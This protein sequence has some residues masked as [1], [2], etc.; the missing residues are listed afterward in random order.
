MAEKTLLYK[1][2]F[3]GT[4]KAHKNLKQLEGDLH[5]LTKEQ[6]AHTKAIKNKDKLTDKEIAKTN[7]LKIALK[8]TRTAIR[9]NRNEVIANV[10]AS[11]KLDNSYNSLVKRNKSLAIAVKKLA[12]PLTK[13]K[14]KFD[15]LTA[16]INKNNNSLKAMDKTMGNNQRNV[17][18]YRSAVGGLTGAFGVSLNAASLFLA[19]KNVI[20][21]IKEFD[22]KMATVKAISGATASEFDRLKKSAKELGASTMFTATQVGQLQLEFSKLGFSTEEILSATEA[23]LNLATATESDLGESAV[24]AASTIRGFGLSA[25]DT[26]KVTDIMAKS[27]TSSA[28]DLQKFGTSM[29]IIA[30]VAKNSN[31]TLAETTAILGKVM[32]AGVDASSAGTALRNIFLELSKQGLT[33]NQAMEKIQKS[34]NKNKVAMDLFGKRGAS[35]ANI[36][37]NNTHE[38]GEFK[39][40]L[41]NSAGSAKTMADIVGDT[42]HG[43]VKRLSSAWEG[44]ILGLDS[45]DGVLSRTISGFLEMSTA[46][47]SAITPMHRQ[48]EAIVQEKIDTELLVTQIQL[49]NEG[50]EE[51]IKLINELRVK[52]PEF[53]GKIKDEAVTN[54]LLAKRIKEVNEQMIAKIVLAH[55]QEEIEEQQEDAASKLRA[56]EGAK[57]RLIHSLI[58]ARDDYNIKLLETGTLEER[59][60]HARKELDKKGILDQRKKTDGVDLYMATMETAGNLQRDMGSD[61]QLMTMFNKDYNSELEK[62]NNLTTEK[63]KLARELGIL[64]GDTDEKKEMKILKAGIERAHTIQGMFKNI[65]DEYATL[66][67]NAE[68][69]V[70]NPFFGKEA[71]KRGEQAKE[72][73]IQLQK[74]LALV[75]IMNEQKIA[76]NIESQKD[77]DK[78]EK[79]GIKNKKDAEAE[80]TRLKSEKNKKIKEE[81]KKAEDLRKA[82]L[83]KETQDIQKGYDGTVES[84]KTMQRKI[85]EAQLLSLK[86]QKANYEKYGQSTIELDRQISGMQFSMDSADLKEKNK[87]KLDKKAQD[88]KDAKV[89]DKLKEQANS[90]YLKAT[91]DLLSGVMNLQQEARE[92]EVEREI[93]ML[94]IKVHNGLISE[95]EFEK[96]SLELRKEAFAKQKKTEMAMAVIHGAV[97]V[98]KTIAQL[99]G[100]GAITP[101][102][103][104][105]IAS[106][107]ASTLVQ[108]ALIGSQ[109]F[110][111]GGLVQGNSHE[112]G[113]E[114]FAVGGK[115]SELEGGEAVINKRSTNMFKPILSRI[116]EVGGGKK[117][118]SGGVIEKLEQGGRIEP[119]NLEPFKAN[120]FS[121]LSNTE[122]IE[123]LNKGFDTVSQNFKSLKVVNVVTDT[124]AKQLSITN[125]ENEATI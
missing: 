57:E 106:M 25:K 123:D 67:E 63:N 120:W 8:Q 41:D 78:L 98:M 82:N 30:P 19:M 88:K 68:K 111:R 58:E 99:G 116:N 32:D 16:S 104:A 77:I 55:K 90:N 23:T 101:A 62:T 80:A 38:I 118:A 5:K 42:L 64:T 29:A 74:G 31:F 86:I 46:I 24:I 114:K 72:Q 65:S 61:L 84:Y 60:A 97:A 91:E 105:L 36:I 15:E 94:Q 10:N 112:Q 14:R 11:K 43:D 7:K 81:L 51:R 45:G 75:R 52:Y 89:E 50:T 28:L 40:A 33:W 4:M 13:D 27:F 44:F 26:I 115:V 83:L 110:R 93:E 95:Q 102:G 22:Q 18:N 66:N 96:K 9:L 53:L 87:I 69:L 117:F 34:T 73:L 47:L 2:I 107:V 56:R 119:L 108:V 39:I 20:G 17:G 125:I 54:E 35:V 48:S 109:K 37:A 70:E 79:K 92:R 124:T 85:I 21:T 113:G 103:V 12:N 1:L 122:L 71:I 59:V 49:T 3:S 76:D 6:R 121:H 100:V